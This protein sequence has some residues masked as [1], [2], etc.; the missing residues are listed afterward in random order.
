MGLL[1]M[2]VLMRS[3]TDTLKI[4]D[5][6]MRHAMG[7]LQRYSSHAD[8]RLRFILSMWLM[9]SCVSWWQWRRCVMFRTSVG[10]AARFIAA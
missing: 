10:L 5:K 1:L 7:G 3:S 6:V 8:Q 9:F 2:S 4:V